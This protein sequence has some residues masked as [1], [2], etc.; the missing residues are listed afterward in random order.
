V[1]GFYSEL[2]WRDG[3]ADWVAEP[4]SA[5]RGSVCGE[6]GWEWVEEADV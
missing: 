3:G 1:A 5:V 2:G 4:V 6:S